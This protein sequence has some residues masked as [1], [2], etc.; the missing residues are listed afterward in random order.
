M[1]RLTLYII[2]VVLASLAGAYAQK[3]QQLAPSYAWVATQPLGLHEP[4]TIDTLL[5]N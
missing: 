4:S 2:C 3:K 5:Y 1:K